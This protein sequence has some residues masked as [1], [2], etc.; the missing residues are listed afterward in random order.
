MGRIL[1]IDYGEKR[2][3]LALTDRTNRIAIPFKVLI[4]D[5]LLKN[6]LQEL[7][8]EKN[9]IK[10]VIG[11]PLN[12]KGEYGN[13]AEKV[14]KFIDEVLIPL[15]LPVI[16]IDERL[17]SKISGNVS[18][19]NI[20]KSKKIKNRSSGHIDKISSALILMDYLETNK[21]KENCR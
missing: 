1:G 8:K 17:T 16:K 6:K 19:I 11:I 21:L 5:E 15:G 10:I 2:I 18:A 4:N 20:K 13:Q 7:I 9:I 12:L 3:G 14:L